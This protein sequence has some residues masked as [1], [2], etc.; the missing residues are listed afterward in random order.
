MTTTL[1]FANSTVAGYSVRTTPESGPV[2][3]A[4]NALSSPNFSEEVG[5]KTLVVGMNVMTAFGTAT[6]FKLQGATSASG[7]YADI[8]V[9]NASQSASVGTYQYNVSLSKV[10]APYY[11]LAYNTSGASIGTSGTAEFFYAYND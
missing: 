1:S 2:A 8:S 11:R 9:L 4:T 6:D 5:G 3:S 10:T 7:P